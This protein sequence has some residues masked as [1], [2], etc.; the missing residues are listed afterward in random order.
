VLDKIR[1][2]DRTRLVKRLGT[3][4]PFALAQSLKVLREMFAV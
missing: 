4:T 3:W 1:T 2:V